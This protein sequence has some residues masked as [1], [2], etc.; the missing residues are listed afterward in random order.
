MVTRRMR[1]SR[2]L[3]LFGD[4]VAASRG[5]TIIEG[6]GDVSLYRGWLSPERSDALLADI[7]ANTKW[8]QERRKMYDRFVDVPREQAW[9]G[10]DRERWF[11][12]LLERVRRDLEAFTGARF[13][14]VLLNRYRN[15]NDSV[16]WHHDRKSNGCA[17]P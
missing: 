5:E 3:P 12:P 6:D 9:F 2:E 13:S 14:C 7:R 4:L 8:A 10:L 1:G 16:A 15:G 17:G 11:T